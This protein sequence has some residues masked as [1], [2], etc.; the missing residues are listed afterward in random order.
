M[1]EEKLREEEAEAGREAAAEEE[2]PAPAES[3]ETAAL[4][5][6]LESTQ[7]RVEQ[8][9]RERFLLGKGVPEEDLDYYVFKIGRLVTEDRD[10]AEAA[11][12]FLKERRPAA[13]S[14]GASLAGRGGR[15]ESTGEIMNRLLRSC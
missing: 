8:L 5:Q 3:G 4:R 11:K 9:E 13:R 7:A 15:Q 6:E 1:T 10:F 2:S 12:S 14:T